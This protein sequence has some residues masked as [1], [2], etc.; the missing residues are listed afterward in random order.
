M[1]KKEFSQQANMPYPYPM[2]Y[3]DSDEIDLIELFRTL[4]KQKAKIALVTVVTTL[5]A[6]IYAFTAEEV[7]TSKAVIGAPKATDMDEFYQ[8]AQDVNRNAPK[9]SQI[10]NNQANTNRINTNDTVINDTV[11]NDGAEGLSLINLSQSLYNDFKK[12]LVA[13][14]NQSD[15]LSEQVLHGEKL[16]DIGVSFIPSDGKKNIYDEVSLSANTPLLAK[17]LLEKYLMRIS[18]IAL[19]KNK[20]ELDVI[21]YKFKQDL[22]LESNKLELKAKEQRNRV[23][24]NII[25]ALK[26]AKKMNISDSTEVFTTE[27][28]DNTMYLLGGKVLSE[29]LAFLQASEPVFSSRYFEIQQQL[30]TLSAIKMTSIAGKTFSYIDE[31]SDPVKTKPK[32]ILIVILGLIVG[33]MFG[34]VSVLVLLAFRK[35]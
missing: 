22:T 26:Q 24:N 21:N 32:K 29:K 15:F 2:P 11:I 28:N 34:C 5:A 16:K 1:N 3:Q 23:M 33:V 19:N 30:K 14:R 8:V 18:L 25:L 7:W 4:W 17:Q 20:K 9:Q 6:G 35:L 10:V 27:I 12:E 31:P 13:S